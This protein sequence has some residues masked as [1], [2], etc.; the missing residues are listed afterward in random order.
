MKRF[1][2][3]TFGR[4]LLR[5]TAA[6]AVLLVIAALAALVVVQSGWFHEYVR[7]RI[8]AEL[9]HST[10]GRVEIGRFSFRGPTLTASVA[11]LVIHG[12]EAAGEP[13]LLQVDSVTLGLR[14]L[15][16]A[17]RKIDLASL[18]IEKPRV[19]IVVYPDG[20]NNIPGRSSGN[21]AEQVINLAV[22]HYE[23]TDGTIEMDERS[24]P[25]N[26]RG[27]GLVL[28]PRG[29]FA[30][31]GRNATDGSVE[32]TG[33]GDFT[34]ALGPRASRTVRDVSA[35][36]FQPGQSRWPAADPRRP[37]P[38]RRLPQRARAG[39]LRPLR[40]PMGACPARAGRRL[41]RQVYPLNQQSPA[42]AARTH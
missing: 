36:M 32:Q 12:N 37:D 11:P 28:Y 20:S 17:E 34:H 13:P 22:G 31:H 3:R 8:I 40:H 10:G 2:W 9:E 27:D 29:H 16:I 4:I 42:K 35:T 41:G 23:V 7:Q 1:R 25:L 38:V 39:R 24:T 21:W 5:V 15:S 6:V 14:I 33:C 19:R 18:K 26:L 30:P